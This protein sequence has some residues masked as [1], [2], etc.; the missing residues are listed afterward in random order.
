MECFRLFRMIMLF[1]QVLMQIYTLL[2]L[3]REKLA[4]FLH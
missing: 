2:F 4:L 1:L 3:T